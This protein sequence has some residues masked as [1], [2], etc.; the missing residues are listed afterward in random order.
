MIRLTDEFDSVVYPTLKIYE[1]RL[2][3]FQESII[4]I[5]FFQFLIG[6]A[7][8]QVIVNQHNMYLKLRQ[9]GGHLEI[10]QC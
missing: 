2:M 4:H 5:A 7:F 1:T 9:P 6:I 3:K 10:H 8:V